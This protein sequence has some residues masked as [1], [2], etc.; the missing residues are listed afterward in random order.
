MKELQFSVAEHF[1]VADVLFEKIAKDALKQ[2]IHPSTEV[3][4]WQIMWSF[5]Q[6][7][8][9]EN[10]RFDVSEIGTTW[11]GSYAEMD[12]LFVFDEQA[13]ASL[14]GVDRFL[15]S[16]WKSTSLLNENRTLAIPWMADTRV[17]Y[18]WRDILEDAGVDDADAFE[19]PEKMDETLARLQTASKPTWAVPTFAVANTVHQIASWIWAMGSD[20]LSSDA[21]KTEFCNPKAIDGIVDY[22]NLAKYLT[23]KYD[24]WDIVLEAFQKR[25]AAVMMS[26]PWYMKY[27][28]M[29]GLGSDK[30]ENLGVALPPGPPFVGGSNL[31]I[32]R[33]AGQSKTEMA[34]EWVR[35]LTTV[36]VQ[37]DVCEATG[38]LP[39]VRELLDEPPYS[40]DRRYRVFAKAI[41]SGRPMPQ[42]SFWGTI[43][44]EL[45]R[46]FGNIWSEL[47][48]DPRFSVRQIVLRYL[49]PLAERYDDKLYR[50]SVS[51]VPP[52]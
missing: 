40:T 19:T 43:E 33:G 3:I 34:L 31:V 13:K 37:R 20:F 25:K 7:S 29:R 52:I 45:V 14:G 17:I 48:E 49:E 35:H 38:L 1:S 10:K 2:E 5:L 32:W 28:K 18:Y 46:V 36:S 21:M 27:L 26:G 42:V 6:R 47:K 16:A 50:H 11:V 51:P 8:F 15:P 9:A 30:I 41:E 4:P 12:A 24:S 39:T 44:A 23:R 22:F